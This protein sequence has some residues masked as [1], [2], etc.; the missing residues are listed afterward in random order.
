MYLV[1]Y[2]LNGNMKRSNY[3]TEAGALRSVFKWLKVNQEANPKVT[4]YAPGETPQDFSHFQQVPYREPKTFNFYSS[5]KWLRL[6]TKAFELYG[7]TCSCCGASPATGAVMHVDHI[8]PRST[9]PE[10]AYDIDNLQILCEHCNVGK[11]NLS[12]YQ[13]RSR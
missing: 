13:W 8:R 3:K 10:L 11:S 1:S 2:Y 7:N 12:T 9:H 5:A 4:F 6:R